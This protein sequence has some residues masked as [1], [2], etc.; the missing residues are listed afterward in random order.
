[1]SGRRGKARRRADRDDAVERVV[2]DLR[3]LV[4]RTGALTHAVEDL[5]DK[6][7]WDDRDDA[8]DEDRRL[9]HLAHLIEITRETAVSAGDL[10]E[11]VSAEL[12]RQRTR[13]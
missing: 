12:L 13:A 2:D 1:V 5:Y 11:E 4:A 3:R 10:G 6:Y 9:E 7:I 8:R